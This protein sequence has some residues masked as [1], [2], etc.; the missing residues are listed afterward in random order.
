MCDDEQRGRIDFVY[1]DVE[2]WPADSA[3][4]NRW[5]RTHYNLWQL[6]IV[7]AA[8]RL[9]ESI[10]FDVV[11]HVTYGQYWSGSWMGKLGVPFVWGPLGGGERAPRPLVEDFPRDGR[12]HE[13][14]RDVAQAIGRRTL[15]VN[16]AARR[17]TLILA[18]TEE[19]Q[20]AMMAQGI[21]HVEVMSNSALPDAEVTAEPD[22]TRRTD[23]VFRVV[24]IGR[25][26]HWKGFHLVVQ[27]FAKFVETNPASALSIIGEGPA[28]THLRGLTEKYGL[29][30][31]VQ[32]HGRVPRT[33]VLDCLSRSH[34]LAH[35][36]MHDSAGWVT[37]EAGAAGLPVVCLDLGGPGL[38]V[39][40]ETGIKI[41]PGA[42]E[43]VVGAMAAAFRTLAND[44]DHARRLGD[45]A[46]ARVVEHFT[47]ARLGDRLAAYEP[48]RSFDASV[49]VAEAA[50]R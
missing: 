50:H 13:R 25:L 36:S 35:P 2:G 10:G 5:R 44:R 39:T 45:A 47:W 9:H 40:P 15:P 6:R 27:A 23:D 49:P 41:S 7:P 32:L 30:E 18:T 37:L 1:V 48:Y 33:D 3:V 8:R 16:H 17:A 20:R 11:H 24:C 34:V 42:P 26:E 31:K 21:R 4:A 28:E 43:E 38:Q 19:T 46:R 14:K 12:L 22:R 29:G